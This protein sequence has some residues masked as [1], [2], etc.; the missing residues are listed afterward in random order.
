MA[1]DIRNCGDLDEHFAPFV[2]GEETP[3]ARAAI[4]SHL[5][6]CPPCRK[7]AV[8][9]AAAREVVHAHREALRVPAPP[10]L[11]LRCANL[12]ATAP[13]PRSFVRRWAPLSVAATLLLAVGGVFVFGL[14]NRVDA[15]AA[16]LTV[17][18][19]KCFKVGSVD[20]HTN[21]ALEGQKWLQNQGWSVVV[22]PA[23]AAEQL[24]LVAVRKCFS[25]NGRAAHMMYTWR[26]TP[27]SLFVMPQDTRQEQV[28][29]RLGHQAV[30][31]FANERT[32]AIVADGQPPQD[33][34][35]I[36]D[37]LRTNAK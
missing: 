15:L 7:Q 6:A 14:N 23:S 28:V 12:S 32:Y 36:V 4:E 24:Q 11:R 35:R 21:H 16:S 34:T 20:P 8:S 33:F 30:I 9:E 29:R 22:P 19:V 25:T 5:A 3:A 26:G 13:A 37:Y 17:D 1:D 10:A 27:V 2:D 31:W 18:H